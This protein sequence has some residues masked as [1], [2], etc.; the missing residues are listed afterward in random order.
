MNAALLRI[1]RGIV[2]TKVLP[3]NA[4]LALLLLTHLM[5]S[6]T[7]E[8]YV[9]KRETPNNLVESSFPLESDFVIVVLSIFHQ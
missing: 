7:R 1:S 6:L 5:S 3:G 9:E 2:F 4:V 8:D